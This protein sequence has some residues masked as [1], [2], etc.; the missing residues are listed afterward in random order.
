MERIERYLTRNPCYQANVNKQDSRYVDFQ[1][2]GPMG[3]MLH[4]VGCAQPSA[5]VFV[6]R[7]NDPNYDRACVHAF[8]DANT[9]AV[10]QTLPWNFRGWHCGGS[11]NNTHVGIELCEPA[12][13][14][15]GAGGSFTVKDRAAAVAAARRTWKS[16]VELFAELCRTY[17]LDPQTAIC[18]HRE[19]GRAGIASGHQDPEHLWQGLGLDYTMDGFR[20]AVRQ[21]LEGDGP[22]YRIQ[23]GAFRNRAYAEAF[24]A[25][26]RAQFPEAY[27][28]RN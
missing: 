13:L 26:V 5:E 4:S 24:L 16:A 1:R 23:V 6:N 3:L 27:L 20:T 10:W 28:T 11:G 15:Y 2:R 8:I 19:G 18:S 9:G 25:R 14:V 7:W 12:G 21:K 17:G 22:I